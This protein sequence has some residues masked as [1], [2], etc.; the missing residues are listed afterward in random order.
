MK[1]PSWNQP[2]KDEDAAV[3]ERLQARNGR[4]WKRITKDKLIRDKFTTKSNFG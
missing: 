2:P 1:Q 3:I 4:E